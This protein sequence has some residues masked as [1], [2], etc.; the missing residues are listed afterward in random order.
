MDINDRVAGYRG[1]VESIAT[2]IAHYRTAIRVGA[3]FDDL[4]QEGLIEV[5]EALEE[6]ADPVNPERIRRRMIDYIRAGARVAPPGERLSPQI[7]YELVLP[8]DDDL[9]AS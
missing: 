8:L 7:P 5:W 4:A 1:L 6:G 9:A 3:D 2:E